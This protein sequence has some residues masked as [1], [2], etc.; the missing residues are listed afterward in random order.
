[1]G[2]GGSK[3][4]TKP[5]IL[6]RNKEKTY[7]LRSSSLKN[8]LHPSGLHGTP[9]TGRP[10]CRVP[11]QLQLLGA[12]LKA[13]NQRCISGKIYRW[14]GFEYV[15]IL[16]NRKLPSS[17][18]DQK[19]WEN[20]SCPFASFNVEVNI[21]VEIKS[22]GPRNAGLGHRKFTSYQNKGLHKVE[23]IKIYWR[24]LDDIWISEHLIISSSNI[25]YVIISIVV[26]PWISYRIGLIIWLVV[27]PPIWKIWVRQLGWWHSQYFWENHP[28]MFQDVPG[29]PPTRWKLNRYKSVR[30]VCGPE[31][32]PTGGSHPRTI[33]DL[34]PVRS[35]QN[36]IPW[37]ISNA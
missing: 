19:I 31:P 10:Q 11:Q 18:P 29:K 9:Q 1:M 21:P 14:P 28:V 25:Q 36:G 6:A 22:P 8:S 24:H 17:S 32:G 12:A 4:Q 37:P 5:E 33:R 34:G 15:W 13:M 35:Q 23:E 7:G 16:K 27:E 30:A 26:K 20:H 3:F 2:F